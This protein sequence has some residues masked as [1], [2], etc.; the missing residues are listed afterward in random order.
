MLDHHSVLVPGPEAGAGPGPGPAHAPTLRTVG[1]LL[2]ALLVCMGLVSRGPSLPTR[3]WLEDEL[4][5]TVVA[6]EVTPAGG[7][8]AIADHGRVVFDQLRADF[9]SV[10]NWPP[11][12]RWQMVGLG[13]GAPVAGNPATI[14]FAACPG[15][16]GDY[17][18]TPPWIFG[19]IN[20]PAI[21][22]LEVDR[23]G[24]TTSYPVAPPGFA[25]QLEPL[26]R[27]PAPTAYRWLDV[28]GTVVWRADRPV[29]GVWPGEP[30]VRYPRVC[31]DGTT[32]E[33][34]ERWRIREVREGGAAR[35][36]PAAGEAP[37]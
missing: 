18:G 25:V 13:H 29:E 35:S 9:W 27:R 4:H 8:V 22:A 5:G 31:K 26:D 10:N 32:Q 33:P 11:F 12:W 21:V 23:G 17:C 16:F 3:Q 14:A 7:F 37:S 30:R 24:V 6:Y 19:Q 36:T 15:V 2:A 28:E 34:R 1:V 20:D